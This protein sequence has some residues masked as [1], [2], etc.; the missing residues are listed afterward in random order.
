M[1]TVLIRK[2]QEWAFA[3]EV[4]SYLRAGWTA[5]G[6]MAIGSKSGDYYI[7]MTNVKPPAPTKPKPAPKKK[8]KKTN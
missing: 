8:K 6:G 7:L 2:E 1:A 4:D 3:Q 5:V